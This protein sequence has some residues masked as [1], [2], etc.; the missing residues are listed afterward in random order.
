MILITGSTGFLGA[1]LL[2]HLL[3]K[4]EKVRAMKRSNSSFHILHNVFKFYH[5]KIEDFDKQLSWENGDVT[6]VFSVRE[7]MDGIT[8]VYHC[9]AVVS[10]QPGDQKK[11][12]MVNVRGTE[13]MVNAALEKG[14]RKFCFVSSIAAMGRAEEMQTID[15]KITWKA[16]RNNSR[17][18]VSKYGAEREVWR[19]VE[20]GLKAVIVNP[21]IILG[22]GEINAG[23][24]KMIKTVE[25]GLKFYTPGINGFVDVRDVTNIM[26]KL[27]ESEISNERFVVSSENLN[28]KT[29][30]GYMAKYLDK[31]SPKYEAKKWM[32]E[33]VWRL[34]YL[35][36]KLLGNKPL[37]TR[38]TAR[39][40]GNNY[41]YSNAKSREVLNISYIPIEQSVKDACYFYKNK[42]QLHKA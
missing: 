42:L 38:E 35:K 12:E 3:K 17:Y 9:A 20:E 16:S 25:N 28:Y 31:P 13:N 27:M 21:S 22:P 18:A 10:F 29:L 7:L 39:T 11:M 41:A 37:I 32:G 30:F 8:D 5:S 6:D 15:E 2:Y 33:I 4:G 34:E 14:I 19:G 1:H 26:I 23:S 40:A 36:S 24:T